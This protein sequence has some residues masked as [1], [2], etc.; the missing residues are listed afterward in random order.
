LK[1]GRERERKREYER[2]ESEIGKKKEHILSDYLSVS[3]SGTL[4][5]N[6]FL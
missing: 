5:R 2:D 6:L 1:S 4:E 3:S